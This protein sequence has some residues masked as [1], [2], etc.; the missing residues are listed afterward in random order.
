M[1]VVRY[2]HEGKYKN[3]IKKLLLL[4]PF[5]KEG[6]QSSENRLPT[7]QL[8]AKAQ[9]MI[10][11]G[12][13]D[14]MITSDME[15]IVVSYKTFVSWY[16]QD[17]LGR[18]FEFVTKDYDFPALHRINIPTKVIVGSKDEFFH[19][20]NPDHPEE[21]M[22]LLL[23]NIPNSEGKIIEGAVHSFAP[24]QNILAEEVL[25]FIKE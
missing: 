18:M 3:K 14:E 20:S 5:D 23:K 6:Q 9:E 11:A 19:L 12:K 17:E 8:L 25:N 13:G 2:L 21:A 1:K 7:Q 4:S 22:N 16:K 15:E 24:H 10:D